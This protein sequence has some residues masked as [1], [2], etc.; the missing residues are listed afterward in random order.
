MLVF[1]EDAGNNGMSLNSVQPSRV[2]LPRTNQPEAR[3]HV[4][5]RAVSS[6]L[7][8]AEARV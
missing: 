7:Y 1:Y 8:T 2:P 4:T 6:W 5:A 3:G